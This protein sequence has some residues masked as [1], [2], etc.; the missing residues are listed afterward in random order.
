MLDR[1]YERRMAMGSVAVAGTHG[2]LIPPS[3]SFT[4]YSRVTDTSVG[5]LFLAGVLPGIMLALLFALYTVLKAWRF[6]DKSNIVH[7]ED[8]HEIPLTWG[9]LGSLLMIPLV[10]GGIYTG[11]FTPT[12]AAGVGVVYALLLT[13]IL[14]RTLTWKRF[15]DAARDSVVTSAMILMLIAGA[16]V[17]GNTLSLLRVPQDVAM[18]LEGMHL[19]TW[20]FLIAVNILYLILGMF[21]DASAAILVTIP[22]LLPGLQALHIDLIWFGVILVM[23]ME[24]G[25]VTPPVGMNLFV[26]QALREDFTIREVLMGSLPYACVGLLGLAIVMVFPQLALMLPGHLG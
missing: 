5:K 2:I 18:W 6:S 4:L 21:M 24:I 7:H 1:G 20:Q 17:F 8:E 14:K 12:E 10:L 23:N 19:A 13:T 26:V 11:W 25:A 3:M 15:W 16:S 9:M 22:I